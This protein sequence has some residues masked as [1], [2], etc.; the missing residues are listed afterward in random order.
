MIRRLNWLAAFI[1]VL[2]CVAVGA[3]TV[4]S[5]IVAPSGPPDPEP[6]SP[7]SAPQTAAEPN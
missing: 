3:A 7:P 6:P 1:C 4:P 2:D 5:S